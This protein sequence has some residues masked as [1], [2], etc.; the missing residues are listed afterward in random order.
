MPRKSV[1]SALTPFLSLL[2]QVPDQEI[3][4]K[5]G[6]SRAVTISYRKKLGIAAYEGHR[7]RKAE[8][9]APP[10]SPKGRKPREEVVVPVEDV[11]NFRGRR[12]ALDA[13]LDILGKVPDAEVAQKASVTPENVRT[14]RNR[15][16]IPAVWRNNVEEAHPPA[17]VAAPVAA[18]VPVAA[19]A[20][21]EPVTAPSQAW[22]VE[23]E[24]GTQQITGVVIASSL[25][26][27]AEASVSTAN[28]RYSGGMVRSIRWVGTI[29]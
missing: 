19:P 18:P 20:P 24:Q 10:P 13:W 3:A 15:R 1:A 5:A 14:Y 21:A 8:E 25:A 17:P 23:V 29:L 2:G 16:G 9:P 11:P 6:I 22:L 12:S 7:H 26:A 28:N 4:D 27:A